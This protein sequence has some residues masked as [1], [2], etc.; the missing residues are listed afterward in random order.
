MRLREA[1]FNVIAPYDCLMCS[2]EGTLVC[3]WCWPEIFEVA[4]EECFSCHKASP[5]AAVCNHC[6]V[7]APL[8]HVWVV[9]PYRG[10]ARALV[11]RMKI[12]CYRQACT[13]IAR[14]MHES[15]PTL[16]PGMVVTSVP[17]AGA[18]IRERGFDH[19]RLI[20]EEF[21]RAR[22]LPY[23]PLLVR[24]GR[25][26]Q[27]GASKSERLRQIIGNYQA[28]GIMPRDLPVLVIDDVTTTGATLSEVAK[29][30]RQAGVRSVDA[31]VFAQ[32]IK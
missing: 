19:S 32:T 15:V 28:Y 17:T 7:G 16:S 1:I 24:Y 2:A 6:R 23:R 26:K 12:D 8:Q 21:A 14:A 3:A 11:R 27:A 9:T 25:T 31:L 10:G 18:R 4:A 29:V 13:I 5:G 22:S 20:A 30:L